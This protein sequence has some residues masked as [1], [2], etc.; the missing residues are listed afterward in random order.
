MKNKYYLVFA[1]TLFALLGIAYF[2]TDGNINFTRSITMIGT[3][4]V[5]LIITLSYYI[6]SQSVNSDNPNKFVRNI[7]GGT[8]LKFFLCIIA[9]AILLF[10][11]QK[12][13]HKPDLFLLMFVYI[14]FTLI[15]T[16]FLF[17]ASQK[18]VD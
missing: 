10:T 18:K 1:I 16:T 9:V 12:K 13:L 14:I 4:V 8:F 7:M 6:S 17:K 5:G 11:V 2:L 15:E 3:S